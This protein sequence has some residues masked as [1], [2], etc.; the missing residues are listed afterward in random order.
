MKLKSSWVPN[1]HARVELRNGRGLS[2]ALSGGRTR[3]LQLKALVPDL[4]SLLCT[5]A[6]GSAFRGLLGNLGRNILCVFRGFCLQR[7]LY[8]WGG[9]PVWR[10]GIQ[11]PLYPTTNTNTAGRRTKRVKRT[12]PWASHSF[13]WRWRINSPLHFPLSLCACKHNW[14]LHWKCYWGEQFLFERALAAPGCCLHGRGA[15][16]GGQGGLFCCAVCGEG[17]DRP[18]SLWNKPP[19]SSW[20]R[21][22]QCWPGLRRELTESNRSKCLWKVPADEGTCWARAQMLLMQENLRRPKP[23]NDA[24]R[25]TEISLSVL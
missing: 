20:G 11:C 2:N 19:C 8:A 17:K 5:L 3:K 14:Y 25:E 1:P 15:V 12:K 9:K 13:F 24:A 7:P 16:Q 6:A 4:L 10:D 23:F 18:V 21:G 22:R